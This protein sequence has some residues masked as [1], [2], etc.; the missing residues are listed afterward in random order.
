M[1]YCMIA[2]HNG[3]APVKKKNCFLFQYQTVEEIE[4]NWVIPSKPHWLYVSYVNMPYCTS[5]RAV[6]SNHTGALSWTN[7]PSAGGRG[8]RRL[9]E[10]VPRSNTAAMG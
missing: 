9:N 5:D 8:H 1:N 4:K 3:M 10:T 7:G 2:K 6:Q